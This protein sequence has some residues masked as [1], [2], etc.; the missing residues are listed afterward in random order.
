MMIILWR[1]TTPVKS[2][3]NYCRNLRGASSG[4][5]ALLNWG[6]I[7][8]EISKDHPVEEHQLQN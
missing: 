6:T 5:M 7:T 8:A 1:P 3:Y 2:M 4:R